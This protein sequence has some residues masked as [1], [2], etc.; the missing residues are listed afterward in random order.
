MKKVLDKLLLP[1]Q[2]EYFVIQ[3]NF[4][5][6]GM[7]DY[8]WHFSEHRLPM[9]M[10]DDARQ[11]FPELFG[12]DEVLQDILEKR[13]DQFHLQ[14]I[15][16]TFERE[17]AF[18]FD[19][20]ISLVDQNLIVFLENVTE[21]HVLRHTL[22]QRAN[23]AEMLLSTLRISQDYLGKVINGMGDVL[24]VTDTQG[25]IKQV[26]TAVC[27]RF[28]Y[29]AEEL[30]DRSIQ[31]LISD[32]N[33]HPERI[34]H[35]IQAS[36]H[37]QTMPL[38]HWQCHSRSGRAI[39]FEFFCNRI[40]TEL[41]NVWNLVYIGRDITARCQAE[42]ETRRAMVRE[43]ELMDL[44]KRFVSMAS[45]E[46]R[47]PV[48]NIISSLDLLETFWG[49]LSIDEVQEYHQYIRK[50]TL[51]I[52]DLIDDLLTLGRMTSGRSA[53]MPNRLNLDSFCCE[54]VQELATPDHPIL[55]EYQGLDPWQRLDEK[56][57]NHILV[58][59]LSNALKYSSLPVTLAV[60]VEETECCFQIRDRGIGIPAGELEKVLLSFQRASNVGDRPGSGLGL[61][62]VEQAVATHR[63]RMEIA[64]AL[65]E[66]T[67]VTV[68]LPLDH[69]D[70]TPDYDG[71]I[72]P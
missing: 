23:E 53:Y 50:A 59:L 47:S 54:L 35:Q 3:P 56:L 72:I 13:K 39:I 8:A 42:E 30:L 49:D 60:R 27:D 63:G 1:N 20:C 4:E 32:A 44:K 34:W 64:S 48:G 69:G 61:A 28:G 24:I 31:R 68:Y 10:G 51:K 2:L 38:G 65:N 58:N 37:P 45:H 52:Q 41:P 17:D 15:S 16:R 7:S 70:F 12:L 29:G 40:A 33:F 22:T 36:P 43:R 5:I 67:T 55:Y 71:D 6:A 21:L 19:I 18:F 9:N 46:L 26:N 14:A 66:G 57:L 62:I 25:L 11:Y